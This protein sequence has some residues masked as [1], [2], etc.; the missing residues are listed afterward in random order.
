MRTITRTTVL[1]GTTGALALSLLLA[2]CT[3]A[4]SGGGSDE[5]SSTEG[6]QGAGASSSASSSDGGSGDGG[7]TELTGALAP[8]ATCDDAGALLGDLVADLALQEAQSSSTEAA[9]TC[10]WS[11]DPADAGDVRVIALQ[12]QRQELSA[13]Q[14]ATQ[15]DTAA[16]QVGGSVMEDERAAPFDGAALTGTTEA[17]GLSV[18]I[19][20][21]VT[22]EGVVVVSATGSGDAPLT[23]EESLDAAFLF[24]E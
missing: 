13:E 16:E 1:A 22:P 11:S 4:G 24:V 14:I 21:A 3:G 19:G 9:S 12:L 6:G 2:G 15:A 20:S 5:S 7:S 17:A 8:L 23:P 18:S 10:A